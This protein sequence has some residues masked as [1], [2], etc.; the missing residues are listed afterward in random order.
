MFDKPLPDPPRHDV[1]RATDNLST[2]SNEYLLNDLPIFTAP[3]SFSLN[4]FVML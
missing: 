1:T 4:I 3:V 2:T